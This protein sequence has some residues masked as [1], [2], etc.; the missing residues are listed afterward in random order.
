VHSVLECVGTE[1][2]IQT[3]TAIVRPGGGIGRVG[4]PHYEAIPDAQTTFYQNVSIA[5]GPAP[6]R[7]YIDELLPDVMEGRIE[8]GRVF[9]RTVDLNG[10]PEGYRA[11]NER[12]A[13]KVMV[14][15]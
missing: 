13:L 14:R 1:Q 5:G 11:M 10:V 2:A 3:S 15:P 4:V 9:D 6:V 8:P 7:A 12:Q